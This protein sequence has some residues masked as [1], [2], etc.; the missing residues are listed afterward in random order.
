MSANFTYYQNI[1]IGISF[2]Y[3]SFWTMKE[4]TIG[5]NSKINFIDQNNGQPIFCQIGAEKIQQGVTLEELWN[6]HADR[7]LINQSQIIDSKYVKLDNSPAK[8]ILYINNQGCWT[9]ILMMKKDKAYFISF[10]SFMGPSEYQST[11]QEM[12]ESIKIIN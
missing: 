10:L 9:D 5:Q 8:K 12:I 6:S 2:R 11:I 3:P 7:N 1:G 4:G